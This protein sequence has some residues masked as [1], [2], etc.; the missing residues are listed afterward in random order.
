MRRIISGVALGCATFALSSHA[1]SDLENCQQRQCYAYRPPTG[2]AQNRLTYLDLS[3]SPPTLYCA[4]GCSWVGCGGPGV[5]FTLTTG[6]SGAAT[7]TGG[8]PE[9]SVDVVGSTPVFESPLHRANLFDL[10]RQ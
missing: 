9:I 4:R 1:Q 3:T 6:T 5:A 10:L 8:V 7:Y 2:V